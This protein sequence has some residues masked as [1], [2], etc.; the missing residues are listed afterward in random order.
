M[1]VEFDPYYV[2]LGIPPEEQPAN[3]YR[4]LGLRLFENNG[5][6]IDNAADRQMAHLRTYQG[7]KNGALTQQLLNEVAAARI[8]LLDPKKRAAY[9]QQVRAKM[10][11]PVRAVS[12][13]QI[14]AAELPVKAAANPWH[15][16]IGDTSVKSSIRPSPQSQKSMALKRAAGKRKLVLGI[17]AAVLVAGAVGVGL[18]VLNSSEADGILVFDWPSADRTNTN[19]AVDNTAIAVPAGGLW[20][21]HCS[22]GTHHVVAQRL[23]YKLDESVSVSAGER[24][25]VAANWKPKATLVLDWPLALRSGTELEIDGRA[26]TPSQQVPL[27]IAVEPGQHLIQITRNGDPP[28][29]TSA[30]VGPDERRMMAISLPPTT[31][32]LIFNWPAGERNDSELTVDGHRQPIG[33][34]A[35]P[36]S[37]RLAVGPGRHLICISRAGFESFSQSFALAA[38]TT[39]SIKPTWMPQQPTPQAPPAIAGISTPPLDENPPSQEAV[40]AL[41]A[42]LLPPSKAEQTRIAKQVEEVYNVSGPSAKDPAK[43]QQLYDVAAK[44]GSSPAERYVI[45]L[46]GADI[47]AAAGD[48]NLAQTGIDTL[49]GNYQIDALA[50]K[51]NLLEEFVD[52]AKPDQV[53]SVLTTAEQLVDQAIA[54]DR[55]DI[56]LMLARTA[57]HAAAKSQIPTRQEIEDRLSRRRHEIRLI[58][59][60]YASATK[61]QQTLDKN[62]ADE[63]ANLAVGRWLCL[64][65][66]DWSTGLSRLRAEKTKS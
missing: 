45:L 6:V 27:E 62:P 20:E 11:P 59:P 65:K 35:D 3:Y 16:L 41:A 13:P 64:Y 57:S 36:N 5:D 49:E 61:A 39:L 42:K 23:A 7:G 26:E 18:V 44:S 47:A 15:D 48:W 1:A 54:A 52:V 50:L 63:E 4:L 43:A 9:D 58:E 32:T 2:W 8:C 10:P 31:A 53:G 56:A 33:G 37:F 51:Q 25:N 30:T 34:G 17:V 24:Q 22:P 66:G 60:I 28:V 55:Y 21:F 29:V 19:V 12:A 46:K 38:G 14:Q 40:P